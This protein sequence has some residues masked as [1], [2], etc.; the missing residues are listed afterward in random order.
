MAFSACRIGIPRFLSPPPLSLSYFTYFNGAYSYHINIVYRQRY[1]HRK[2]REMFNDSLEAY[3]LC[4][5]IYICIIFANRVNRY[6]H[7]SSMRRKGA[8]ERALKMGINGL[9][10]K[11]QTFL[12]NKKVRTKNNNNNQKNVLALRNELE[13]LLKTPTIFFLFT[14]LH[15]NRT[16]NNKKKTNENGIRIW[17]W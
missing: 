11:Q 3:R 15:L 14:F 13:L 5:P 1:L 16:N 17:I 10:E 2:G 7:I 8:F 9:G 4:F 6:I 12:W